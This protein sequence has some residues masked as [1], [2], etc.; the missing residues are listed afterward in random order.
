M[1]IYDYF[2]YIYC[3]YQL[4]YYNRVDFVSISVFFNKLTYFFSYKGKFYSGRIKEVPVPYYHRM[5]ENW[6]Y[7]KETID[8]HPSF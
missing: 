2:Y 5:F 3:H 6:Q 7:H 1:I 4:L 8:C